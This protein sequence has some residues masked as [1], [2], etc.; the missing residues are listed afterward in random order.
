MNLPH[1]QVRDVP[2]APGAPL[3][4]LQAVHPQDGPP[5]SLDQQLRGRVEPEVLPAVPLLRRRPLRLLHPPRG[6]L[7][8]LGVP[9]VPQGHHEQAGTKTRLDMVLHLF[10]T[11]IYSTVPKLPLRR[12]RKDF[13]MRWS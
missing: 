1:E 12:F 13:D 7:V 3:P 4:D 5:L 2:A 9:A 11:H 10:L 8:V 6:R